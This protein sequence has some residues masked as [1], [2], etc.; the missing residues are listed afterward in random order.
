MILIGFLVVFGSVIGGYLMHHGQLMI[1]LQ[2][3]EYIII[4]GAAFGAVLIS[5]PL[6]VVK[7]MFTDS[8]GLIRKN[9]YDHTAY[10][11]LLQLLYKLF[12]VGQ[13]EGLTGL[14][15]HVEEPET[16]T[17][18]KEHPFF[19]SQ[20]HAIAFLSDTV[21]ILLTDRV[22][23]HTLSEILEMDLDQYQEEA[24]I[25]PHAITKVAEALPGFGI[26]AAVLGMIIAMGSI[27]GGAAEVGQKVAAAMVG[28]FLG[29]L[30]AYGVVAPVANAL[31]GRVRAEMAYM[32][33]IRTGILAF[34]RGDK[35]VIALEFARRSVEPEDRPSFQELEQL[36]RNRPAA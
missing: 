21:K 4:I 35:P 24:M 1:L 6:P 28:T 11:E 27:G 36:T 17:L 3:S 26:V 29:I 30:L 25:V 10:S 19:S 15:K 8:F 32:R 12:I 2:V 14:E 23:D 33:C 18:F 9:E 22:E 7:K 20:P 5:Y 31:E 16:S 34:A 13:K